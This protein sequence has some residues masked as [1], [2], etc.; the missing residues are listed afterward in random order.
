MPT[1]PEGWTLWAH[2]KG[3]RKKLLLLDWVYSR[4]ISKR[5]AIKR[6]RMIM[7]S[8]RLKNWVLE[9]KEFNVD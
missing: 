7:K 5:R 8:W 6:G 9:V 1:R 2:E 3:N 4:G